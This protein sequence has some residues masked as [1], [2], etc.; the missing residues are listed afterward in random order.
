VTAHLR[1]DLRPTAETH[2]PDRTETS[3]MTTETPKLPARRPHPSTSVV[4]DEA[5]TAT[6]PEAAKALLEEALAEMVRRS[7]DGRIRWQPEFRPQQLTLAAFTENPPG[8]PPPLP[9]PAGNGVTL[10]GLS[11][12]VLLIGGAAVASQALDGMAWALPLGAAVLVT[13][14]TGVVTRRRSS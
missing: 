13:G 14:V 5:W 10:A 12:S 8:P 2:L 3:D 6:S 7:R 1:N 11:A 4:I 9:K